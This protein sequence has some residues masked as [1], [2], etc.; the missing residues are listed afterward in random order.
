MTTVRCRDCGYQWTY[1]A[2][3]NHDCV[4]RL[5]SRIKELEAFIRDVH[6]EYSIHPTPHGP[7]CRCWP[8]RAAALLGDR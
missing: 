5:R 1:G 6:G 4:D 8:C 7:G 3:Q 2:C